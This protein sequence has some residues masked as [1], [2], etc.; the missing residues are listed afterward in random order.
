MALEISAIE[1][2]LL[3]GEIV[4]RGGLLKGPTV[5]QG[6]KTVQ[7]C[8]FVYLWKTARWLNEFLAG[9]M[10]ATR[11][12]SMTKVPEGLHELRELARHERLRSVAG[13]AN[14]G[15][16]SDSGLAGSGLGS[17]SGDPTAALGFD[18]PDAGPPAPPALPQKRRRAISKALPPTVEVTLEKEGFGPWTVQLLL[19]RPQQAVAMEAST[20]NL[21][22]NFAAVKIEAGAASF[23]WNVAGNVS[24]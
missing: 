12:L 14:R 8:G 6:V 24:E 11:P 19:E 5:V 15:S 13:F 3:P 10:K 1:V 7:G 17:E 16:E 4:L 18:A 22:F 21:T 23:S 9:S 20:E 2:G